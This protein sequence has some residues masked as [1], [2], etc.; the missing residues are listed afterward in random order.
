[1]TRGKTVQF[2]KRIRDQDEL[3]LEIRAAA[4]LNRSRAR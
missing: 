4:A 2:R 1:M 3:L